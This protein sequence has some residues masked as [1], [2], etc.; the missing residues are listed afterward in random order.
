MR[1]LTSGI[2]ELE[3]LQEAKMQATET[4]KIWQ[5]NRTLWTQQKNR[6]K[7][8]S[9]GDYVMLKG[10]KSHLGKFTRK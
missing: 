10:N 4:T 7:Q 8:F 2:I 6:E 3:K 5:W 1:V 9:F